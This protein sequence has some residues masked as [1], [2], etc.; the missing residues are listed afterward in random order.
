MVTE[1]WRTMTPDQKLQYTPQQNSSQ[2]NNETPQQP[3]NNAKSLTQKRAVAE[4]DVKT[5]E[6]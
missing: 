1:S 5:N 2:N 6:Q 4:I 3:V